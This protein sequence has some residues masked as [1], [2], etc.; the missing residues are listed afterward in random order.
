MFWLFYLMIGYGFFWFAITAGPDAM[1]DMKH[2]RVSF[3]F[4]CGWALF[5]WPIP[6]AVA[7]Y[8]EWMDKGKHAHDP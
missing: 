5:L 2:P 3:V 7:A 4:M 6:L 8:N 1:A